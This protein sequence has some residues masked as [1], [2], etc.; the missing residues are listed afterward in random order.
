MVCEYQTWCAQAKAIMGRL[1]QDNDLQP[2]PLLTGRDFCRYE[3]IPG[4][5]SR[6]RE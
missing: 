4:T 1:F 5:L 2:V 6:I 3:T